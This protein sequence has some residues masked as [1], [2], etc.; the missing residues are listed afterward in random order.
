MDVAWSD[1]WP[2]KWTARHTWPAASGTRKIRKLADYD[3]ADR[4]GRSEGARRRTKTGHGG[5]RKQK[6][7]QER[8]SR[9]ELD[10]SVAGGARIDSNFILLVVLSTVV[11]SVGLEQDNIAVVIG[12]MVIAPLLGP[13]VAFAF[14]T[15]IGDH[16]LM[17]SAAK[18]NVLGIALSVAIAAALTFL[19][20]PNSESAELLARSSLHYWGI[21]LALGSGAAAALSVTTAIPA[22]LVGVMVSVALLSPAATLGIM[23]AAHKFDLAV[24]AAMLL[25]A[26]IASINIA[27]QIVFISKGI[28]PRRWHERKSAEKAVVVNIMT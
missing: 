26:N 1:F 27:A 4:C 22:T 23:V 16:A 8:A 20:T 21:A 15:A 17:L 5:G 9:E 11:A 10:N 18:S 12:A 25:G 3:V 6:R 24:G 13:N 28:R 19:V 7:E 14:A 2:V